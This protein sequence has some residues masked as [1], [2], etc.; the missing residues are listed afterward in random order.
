LNA[1]IRDVAAEGHVLGLLSKPRHNDFPARGRAY[2]R[3]AADAVADL[4]AVAEE[5]LRALNWL[6]GFGPDWDDVPLDI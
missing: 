6:C 5:R 1:A 4:G 3:L 2:R